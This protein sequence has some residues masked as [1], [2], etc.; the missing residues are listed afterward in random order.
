MRSF[1]SLACLSVVSVALIGTAGGC[2]SSSGGST[3]AAPKTAPQTAAAPKLDFAVDG[4]YVEACSCKPPCPCELTGAEM[5]CNG[6]GAYQL[7]HGVYGGQDF[8]GSRMAYTLNLGESVHVYLDAPDAA[9]RATLEKFARAALGGFGPIVGVHE[10]KIE[11][12]GHDGAFTVRV[13]GGKTM[14]YTT[15]PVLGG[16]HKTAIS[17]HNTQDAVN[18]IMF[19]GVIV[20]CTFTH[21]GKSLNVPKGRN[22]YFNQNMRSHGK[23]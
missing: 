10:G 1:F 21:G 15:E 8:S 12:V 4:F 17:H 13:D 3:Q 5:G 16:D 14:S 18:P 20:S 7:N 19:Q 9:K 22:S 23:I 11:I 2:A 6:V